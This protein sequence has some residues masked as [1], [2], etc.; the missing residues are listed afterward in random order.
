MIID[1]NF[2]FCI[3]V[4]IMFWFFIHFFK[5]SHSLLKTKGF[6]DF[7]PMKEY[8][9]ATDIVASEVNVSNFFV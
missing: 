5:G 3:L 9:S 2:V 7:D 1:P 4:S 6:K 8:K